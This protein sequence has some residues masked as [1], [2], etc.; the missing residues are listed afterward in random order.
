MMCAV[1]TEHV[2]SHEQKEKSPGAGIDHAP[3]RL[4]RKDHRDGR[5]RKAGTAEQSNVARE[6]KANGGTAGEPETEPELKETVGD[7]L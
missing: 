3:D 2:G 7:E 5:K 4:P 6:Q 1:A